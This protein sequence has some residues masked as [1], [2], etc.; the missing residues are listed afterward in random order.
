[1][2]IE[3]AFRIPVG[4]DEAWAL[5]TDVPRIAPCLPGAEVTQ[6]LGDG[7]YLGEA[8]VRLGP[9]SLRFVGEARFIEQDAAKRV[10]VLQAAAREKT[11]RGNARAVITSRLV[12]AD[13]GTEVSLVTDLQLSGAVAQFGRQGI[14][15][16]VSTALIGQFAECLSQSVT[17]VPVG[18]AAS[19][20]DEGPAGA[21]PPPPPA[22]AAGVAL[23]PVVR[24]VLTGAAVR[25]GHRLGAVLQRTGA[26][27][28]RLG[29]SLQ[30]S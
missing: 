12:A 1:M 23:L 28:Q 15:T 13:E 17:A 30:R 21:V 2:K 5:V 27:L 22:A 24:Q 10:V 18:A 20:V 6:D 16:D 29:E 25:A 9:V 8:A 3:N 4:V 26:L 19:S 14:V 11:G 7:R